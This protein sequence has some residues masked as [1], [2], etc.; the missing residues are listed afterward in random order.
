M[1]ARDARR[2]QTKFMQLLARKGAC[3][4]WRKQ[5]EKRFRTWAKAKQVVRGPER[6]VRAD[7]LLARLNEYGYL[8][9]T[10]KDKIAVLDD[11]M[12]AHGIR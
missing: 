12:K 7:W 4:G 3:Y 8:Y 2:R 11:Y 6:R 5:A 9:E 1:R 10:T